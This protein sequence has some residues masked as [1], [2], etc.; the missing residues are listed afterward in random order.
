MAID[1]KI[2]KDLFAAGISRLIDWLDNKGWDLRIGYSVEDELRPEVKEITINGRQGTEKQL[3]SLLHECGH[4]LVQQN[5][6]KYEK[7]Y[8]STARMNCYAGH[9]Q[10]ERSPKYKVD[11]ISEEIEAWKRGKTLSKRLGVYINEEGFNTL[12]SQCVYTYITWAAK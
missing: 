6:N 11:I 8:P 9:R 7:D 1:K 5:W 10:L 2:Q 4:L 3:Y 12:A